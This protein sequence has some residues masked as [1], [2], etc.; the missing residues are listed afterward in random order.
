MIIKKGTKL[1]ARCDWQ[2]F[3]NETALIADHFKIIEEPQEEFKVG[4]KDN[5]LEILKGW[6]LMDSVKVGYY[7]NKVEKGN[8]AFARGWRFAIHEA[9]KL[10]EK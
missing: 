9:I 8:N 2:T 5:P 1:E 6:Q 4:D 10:L 3:E 7:F